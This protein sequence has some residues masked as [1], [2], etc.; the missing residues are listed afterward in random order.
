MLKIALWPTMC[1]FFNH[2]C[3][4]LCTGCEFSFF[5]VHHSINPEIKSINCIIQIFISLLVVLTVS[6]GSMLKFP[7]VC[8]EAES[9]GK[10][11]FFLFR[12]CLKMQRGADIRCRL[13]LL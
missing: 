9:K 1:S 3:M 13:L 8:V 2:C 5:K 12:P 7:T 10:K 6:D 11:S 4:C